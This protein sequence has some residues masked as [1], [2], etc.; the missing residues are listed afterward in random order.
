MVFVLFADY[1]NLADYRIDTRVMIGSALVIGLLVTRLVET[2]G[3]PHRPYD[4]GTTTGWLSGPPAQQWPDNDESTRAIGA[5]GG[6]SERPHADWVES[7]GDPWPG[8]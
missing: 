2:Y 4:A 8:R 1:S 6:E 5:P 3:R 7:G